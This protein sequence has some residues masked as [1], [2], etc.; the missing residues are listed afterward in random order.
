[1]GALFFTLA[2]PV[3][4]VFSK[5]PVVLAMGSAFLKISSFFYIFIAFGLVLN[6]GLGGAGDTFVPMLITLLS[7]WVYL[8]PMAW[9]LSKYTALG[10]RGIW[11]AMATS[12]AVNA[13]LII[14]WFETG[15]WRKRQPEACSN[16]PLNP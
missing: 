11:W 7:L 14:I 8:V 2:G 13:I 12:H 9:W 1:M 3:I 10:V 5:D 15:R 16:K 4:S 6:R